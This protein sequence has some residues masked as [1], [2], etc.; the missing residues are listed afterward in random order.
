MERRPSRP[1]DPDQRRYDPDRL[2][3]FPQSL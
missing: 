3:R 1:P 2:L